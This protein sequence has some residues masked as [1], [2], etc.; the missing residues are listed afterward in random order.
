MIRSLF[1]TAIIA[2]T[3]TEHALKMS[4]FS[5]VFFN[6]DRLILKN[7]PIAGQTQFFTCCGKHG[8]AS[9]V[10]KINK[11]KAGR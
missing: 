7:I 3:K 4:F 2:S 10:R 9:P 5:V 8:G 11:A 6:P 1:V